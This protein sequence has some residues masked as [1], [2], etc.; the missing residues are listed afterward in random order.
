MRAM[1][2]VLWAALVVFAILGVLG[3]AAYAAVTILG[4]DVGPL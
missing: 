4:I 2:V 3:V 1:R